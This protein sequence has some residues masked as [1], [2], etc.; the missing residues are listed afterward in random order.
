MTIN[1]NPY[2]GFRGEA[3]AAGAFYQSVLGGELTSSTF[4]EFGMPVQPGEEGLVMHSQLVA[5]GG[6]ILMLSDRPTGMDLT[7]GDN[8]TVSLSGDD[9]DT[10]KAHFA[11]LAEGGTITM[12]LEKAPWGDWFGELTDKFG[13]HWM[14]NAGGTPDEA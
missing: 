7:P 3:A 6:L 13:I 8:I 11:A 4:A 12:P 1:L 5:P 2:I 14:V 10:L 9:V